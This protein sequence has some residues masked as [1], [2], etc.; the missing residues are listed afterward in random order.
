VSSRPPDPTTS[1]GDLLAGVLKTHNPEILDMLLAKTKDEFLGVAER[2][3]HR[4][5]HLIT[6]PSRP[7]LMP[8][9]S[10]AEPTHVEEPDRG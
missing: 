9:L 10:R 3:L 2:G 4:C 7:T 6:E 8:P 1:L 5:I